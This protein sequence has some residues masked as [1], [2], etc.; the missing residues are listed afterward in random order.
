MDINHM[1]LSKHLQT[2]GLLSRIA[3]MAPEH[4]KEVVMD[5]GTAWYRE[6][7]EERDVIGRNLEAFGLDSSPSTIDAVVE[8]TILHYFE[9]LLPLAGDIALYAEF[10]SSRIDGIVAVSAL[11]ESLASPRGVCLAA[12][13]FGAVEFITPFLAARKLPM[14]VVLKFTTE[15]LSAAAQQQA[16]AM[17]QSGLFSL[18]NIIELGRP[19][20]V[21]A[22]QMAAALRRREIVLSV[23][24]E[25]TP[26]SKPVELFGRGVWGG[27]GIDRMISFANTPVDL[28]AA[29]M[30]REGTERY[31]LELHKID[32][33]DDGRIE[34]IYRALQTVVTRHPAQW[35]FLHEEIPFVGE[36]VSRQ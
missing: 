18:I 33:G 8:N 9:K 35:Y 4:L 6:H 7:H 28:F 15:Q 17:E 10:L 14:N 34:A 16:I 12:A 26:Y 5:L 36:V 13:H 21:A 27:A 29:F 30:V 24:D 23:F 19:K 32:T 25:K 3:G 1:S 2:S 22:M 20:T 11:K 31:R